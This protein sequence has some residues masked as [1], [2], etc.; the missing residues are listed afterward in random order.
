MIEDV[1]GALNPIIQS[2]MLTNE[3]ARAGED[4][5][6]R[7]QQLKDDLSNKQAEQKHREHQTDITHS[8]HEAEM[9]L[10]RKEFEIR[11]QQAD[12]LFEEH[13]LNMLKGKLGL[14]KE[15]VSGLQSGQPGIEIP[16]Y[17]TQQDR[18]LAQL[19]GQAGA[20]TQGQM[21]A[22]QPFLDAAAK[23]TQEN[24]E[25]KLRLQHE[26]AAALARQTGANALDVAKIHGQYQL[27]GDRINGENHL[28]GIMLGVGGDQPLGDFANGIVNRIYS[29][30]ANYKDLPSN[31][32]KVVDR[33]LSGTGE[34]VPTDGKSYKDSLDRAASMQELINRARTLAQNYSRDAK[35]VGSKGNQNITL[36]LVGTLQRTQ[37][38]SDM[39][40]QLNDFKAFGGKLVTEL[41]GMKRSSDADIIRQ[42][43]GAFD[44]KAT[45][46]NNLEKINSRVSAMNQVITNST[47]GLPRD[48]IVKAL[49]D[50]GITDFGPG[51]T[52]YKHVFVN[53]K[54]HEIGS[55]DGQS[56]FDTKTGQK[57]Q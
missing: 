3:N 42:A 17:Q 48:R 16:D 19:R 33:Y 38:G 55:N 4:R 11:K 37:P 41:E 35:G 23:R 46:K 40:S 52:K 39:D 25:K 28:K 36:P 27:A 7:A 6:L 22:Q 32:K 49:G 5:K 20:Q 12:A 53:D 14:A 47:A 9:E 2:M 45:V 50:R 24:E 1:Q 43:L 56:W 44:P 30:Q 26:N 29:G 54:G 34:I 8:E 10:H 57:V 18:F 21:E 13:G 31:E 51:E 15:G